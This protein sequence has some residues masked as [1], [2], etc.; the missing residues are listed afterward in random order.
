M[1]LVTPVL[2]CQ[3]VC[4]TSHNMHQCGEKTTSTVSSSVYIMVKMELHSLN[5]NFLNVDFL[6][7]RNMEN[8]AERSFH[9]ALLLWHECLAGI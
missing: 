3:N 1:S 7:D 4:C 5:F 6:N 9:M 8:M 2:I